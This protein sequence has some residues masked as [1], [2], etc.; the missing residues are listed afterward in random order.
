MESQSD[1]IPALV[2]SLRILHSDIN[3][4][5]TACRSTQKHLWIKLGECEI[6]TNVNS[7]QA[8]Q[9]AMNQMLRKNKAYLLGNKKQKLLANSSLN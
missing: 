8:C 4:L 9:K 6:D 3:K 5:A 7:L 1:Y 2:N